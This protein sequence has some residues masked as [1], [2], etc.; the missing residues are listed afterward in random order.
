MTVVAVHDLARAELV[1]PPADRLAPSTEA[2]TGEVALDEPGV[3]TLTS[4]TR[5]TD[6]PDSSDSEPF[7]GDSGGAF[8]PESSG[9]G[10]ALCGTPANEY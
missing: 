8:S 6:V 3:I 10:Q 1:P 9:A 2:P 4:S 7:S 5:T